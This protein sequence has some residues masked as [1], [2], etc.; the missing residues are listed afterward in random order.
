MQD[1]FLAAEATWGDAPPDRPG[2]WL[3][4]TAF[5]KAVGRLRA[6][7]PAEELS[8][9]VG[10]APGSRTDGMSADGMSAAGIHAVGSDAAG[11]E[12]GPSWAGDDDLFA[13][14]V[15]C[16]HPSLSSEA[17][18]ALTLRHVA[19]LADDQIASLFLAK[20]ATITKR[21]VR[22]RRKIVDAA[23]SFEPPTGDP[24]DGRIQNVRTVLYLMFT[25]GYL[26]AADARLRPDLCEEAIWLGRQ[27]LRLRPTDCET[28]GLI[29]LMR[30]QHCRAA[31]RV[32]DDGSL[33]RF[34]D[35]D[36]R[37]WDADAIEEA[38]SLLSRTGG[39]PLGKFQIEAAIALSHVVGDAPDWARIADLY[40]LLV[41][42]DS[43]IAVGVNR[44]LAVGRADGPPA[45]LAV[46]D[47]LANDPST[48]AA[49]ARYP[50]WHVCRADLLAESG[51]LDTSI[52][53]WK[54]AAELTDN[55]T[56][57]AA[58]LARA[59]ELESE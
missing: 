1:A 51:D 39:E 29:A 31:A 7:R 24:L 32:D 5:R 18:I 43:S 10:S 14:L 47:A 23:I 33:V 17:S 13:L 11:A 25:E 28:L 21:L 46:L 16:C 19:G 54:R 57:R 50:S 27:L 40:Q 55:P 52:T 22:A 26:P 42:F 58:I 9:D 45:G 35:Q 38:K 44:A 6:Q 41:L 34:D 48:A 53:A 2:A 15:T 4:T 49:A 37:L 36:R 20:P 59:R 12:A 30:L 3:Q 8:D 56:E